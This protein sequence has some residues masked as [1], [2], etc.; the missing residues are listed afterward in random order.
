MN[1]PKRKPMAEINVVP[2]ID[3]MLVLLV[4]FM[5]TTPLLS[6]GV[7][8]NLPKVGAEPVD[9]GSREPVIVSIDQAGRYYINYGENKDKPIAVAPLATRIAAVKRNVPDT[10]FYVRSDDSVPYGQ[11]VVLMALMQ[12][13][14]V[15]SVGLMTDQP[16]PPAQSP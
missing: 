5:V 8:V 3:V 4:I 14:G 2:Y 6:Q 10:K 13:A 12:D 16:D 1:R 7:E 11:V 15:E 9:P